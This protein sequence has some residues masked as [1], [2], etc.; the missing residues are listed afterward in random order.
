[1]TQPP[2]LGR[3]REEDLPAISWQAA[4]LQSDQQRYERTL[5]RFDRCNRALQHQRCCAAAHIALM[6]RENL[7]ACGRYE[8][9]P[10]GPFPNVIA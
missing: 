6:A 5:E 1:M 7:V 2:P 9:L 3:A 10:K 8:D 4:E